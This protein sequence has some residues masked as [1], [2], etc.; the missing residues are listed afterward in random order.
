MAESKEDVDFEVEDSENFNYSEDNKFSHEALIMLSI[1]KCMDAGSVELTEGW[2]EN[3]ID[4]N[5]NVLKTYHPDTRKTYINSVKTLMGLA[6]RDYKPET[7]K[8]IKTIM[9][10][11]EEKKKFWLAQEV[12]WWKSLNPMQ[13]RQM[14]QEGK[15]VVDGY[16]NKNLDFDNHYFEDETETYREIFTQINILTGELR[17]FRAKVG[18]N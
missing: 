16:F 7:I 2:W 13:Q 14:A 5:G 17:D 11:L 1:K 8:I 10:K 15:Q 18:R 3:K 6:A 12:R 9:T 4:K